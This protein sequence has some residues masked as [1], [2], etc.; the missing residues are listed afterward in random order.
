MTVKVLMMQVVS[1]RPHASMSVKNFGV[2]TLVE[3]ALDSI[4]KAQPG[5]VEGSRSGGGG[6]IWLESTIFQRGGDALGGL[7]S[8]VRSRVAP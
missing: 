2:M 8:R 4:N 7:R 1:M 5:F 6:E 3:D